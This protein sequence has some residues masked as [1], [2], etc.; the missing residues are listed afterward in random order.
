M[1]GEIK[2]RSMAKSVTWRAT[3]STITILLVYAFTRKP[4]AALAVGGFE[5]VFKMIAYY[6]HERIW[7]NIRWGIADGN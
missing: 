2:T 7:N 4:A 3:A 5:V 1:K 6:M